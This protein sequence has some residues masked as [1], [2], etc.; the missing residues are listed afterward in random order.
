[1]VSRHGD[2]MRKILHI[3]L[4]LLV[5]ISALS[6]NF[7]KKE[8]GEKNYNLTSTLK[9]LVTSESGDKIVVKENVSFKKGKPE[10]N[11]IL[12]N[13]DSL[14]QTID[15]IGTSFTESS[16][17]VLAHLDKD[18]RQEVMENIFSE[19]GANFTL[20]RTHIGA[21]DFSVEG[22]YSYADVKGDKKLENF[23]ISPDKEGF[24]P[25]EYPGIKDENYD[26]LPMIR[27][28][29]EI[30]DNQTDK[31]LRIISSAWTAPSW[32]KDIEE[33]YIPGSPENNWQGTGGSLKEE[34]IP[35]YAD[36][37]VK[38]LDAYQAEGI[39]I[40][41]LTP[42]NEPHGNNGQWESMHFTPESQNEFVKNHLG[43]KLQ[44]GN[45]GDVKLLVYDQNRDGLEHWTDV[46]FADPESG[47]L[48]N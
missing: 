43:P 36:Y 48:D 27:E 15:G 4:A 7:Y 33:W 6:C 1:M 8:A 39:D 14:K 13:P 10:G 20:T 46:I 5:I 3:F 40:W 19:K 42:V 9:V 41:G 11:I 18:K 17:F 45:H 37:I 44:A 28:A 21:C 29:L 16:A 32:M 23:D 24:N 2:M 12:I 31:E 26:L 25:T 47:K 35:T 38:Y 34:Y 30:K 22:K